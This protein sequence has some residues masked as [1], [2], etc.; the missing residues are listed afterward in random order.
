LQSPTRT[1]VTTCGRSAA[2]SALNLWN[3]A[4]RDWKVNSGGKSKEIL[5][6]PAKDWKPCRLRRQFKPST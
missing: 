2:Q 5:V 4:N 6:F 1:F 3:F